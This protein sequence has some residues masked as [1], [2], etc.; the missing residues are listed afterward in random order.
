MY[1]SFNQDVRMCLLFVALAYPPFLGTKRTNAHVLLSFIPCVE[2][3]M[4][5]PKNVKCYRS[6]Q[7]IMIQKH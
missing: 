4:E 3:V 2:E 1:G 7:S 6:V 5:S